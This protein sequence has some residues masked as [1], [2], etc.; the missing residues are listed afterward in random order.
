MLGPKGV[1]NG[2]PVD[3]IAPPK[4]RTLLMVA[5]TSGYV[6]VARALIEE[7]GAD[8]NRQTKSKLETA[9]HLAAYYGQLTIVKLLLSLPTPA[10]C[11]V[12][13]H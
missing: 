2:L 5:A 8:P 6:E 10:D 9:L 4:G 11:T 1:C 13:S 7:F 12:H 3:Y